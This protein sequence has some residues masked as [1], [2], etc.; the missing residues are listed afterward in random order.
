MTRPFRNWLCIERQSLKLAEWSTAPIA[1]T[2]KNWDNADLSSLVLFQRTFHLLF[3]AVVRGEEVG[4]HEKENDLCGF[5]VL[6]NLL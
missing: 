5:E 6:I 3:V 2:Q 4:A 1:W